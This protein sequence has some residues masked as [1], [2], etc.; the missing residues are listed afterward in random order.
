MVS[1]AIKLEVTIRLGLQHIETF[2]EWHEYLL[3][4]DKFCVQTI[5]NAS[6]T[7][8]DLRWRNVRTT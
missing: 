6:V 1:F 7:M 5:L 8:P 2:I 3:H 4:A